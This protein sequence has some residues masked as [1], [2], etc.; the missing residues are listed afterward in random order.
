MKKNNII[1]PTQ[2]MYNVKLPKLFLYQS[3]KKLKNRK[4]NKTEWKK[5]I[6]N[7]K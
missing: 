3:F 5:N 1:A 4:Q 7:K 6:E 2:V